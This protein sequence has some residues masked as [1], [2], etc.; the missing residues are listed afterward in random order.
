MKTIV[1]EK[2]I[3]LRWARRHETNTREIIMLENEIAYYREYLDPSFN[4]WFPRIR[5]QNAKKSCLQFLS[6]SSL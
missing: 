4:D 6:P 5:R 2:L 1:E 3:E